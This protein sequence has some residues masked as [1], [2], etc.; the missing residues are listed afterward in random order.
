MKTKN[1]IAASTKKTAKK[2]RKI[3]YPKFMV[4]VSDFSIL[5]MEGKEEKATEVY[6]KIC[7]VACQL[8]F[9]KAK[10]NF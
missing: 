9:S 8:D 7:S 2:V 1:V 5:R 10:V 6:E 3:D 4:L